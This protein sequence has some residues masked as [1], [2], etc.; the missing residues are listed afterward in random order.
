MI[1]RMSSATACKI[2]V[3][4]KLSAFSDEYSSVF[5][6]QIEG[7]L[8]NK[9]RMTEIRGV[10]GTNVAD[11]TPLQAMEVKKKLDASGISVSA[12]GSPIGKIK[13]TDP[14]EPHLDKLKQVCDTAEILQTNRIRVFSFYIPKDAIRRI[15]KMR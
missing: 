14:M 3:K 9:V 2:M 7:L 5:D 8:K 11:L 15:I 10:D 13:I 12:I 1:G 6:E 4:F